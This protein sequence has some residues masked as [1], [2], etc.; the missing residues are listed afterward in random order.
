MKKWILLLTI[1]NLFMAGP[2]SRADLAVPP[3]GGKTSPAPDANA[4]Q[5]TVLY[6]RL[7]WEL[8][9]MDDGTEKKARLLLTEDTGE[10]IP[11]GT[12][13]QIKAG[14]S[15]EAIDPDK[16]IGKQVAVTAQVQWSR[17]G[18]PVRKVVKVVSI[19]EAPGTAK[20]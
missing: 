17:P 12:A 14:I 7:S 9:K 8:Q 11:L 4:P 18:K 10:I 20:P 13:G 5:E 19:K 16:H 6:G 15:G 2:N 1:G 3:R